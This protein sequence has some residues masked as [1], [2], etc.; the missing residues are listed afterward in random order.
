MSLMHDWGQPRFAALQDATLGELSLE[1]EEALDYLDRLPQLGVRTV[2]LP[3]EPAL[4][5]SALELGLRVLCPAERL[6][7]LEM[8]SRMG[9]GVRVEPE[10]VPAACERDLD[11]QVKL[12]SVGQAPPHRLAIWLEAWKSFDRL[13]LCLED[14]QGGLQPEGLLR[15]LGF[16]ERLQTQLGT[17][18]PLAWSQ[19]DREGMAIF[20]GLS[21][22]EAGVGGVRCAGLGA[23]GWIPLDGLLVN[24]SLEGRWDGPTEWL[25]VYCREL[26]EAAGLEPAANYP[27]AGRDAFRTATG[28]HAMAMWR[29]HQQGRQE[30]VD[31]IYSGVPAGRFG[32]EQTIEVGPMSGRSNVWWWLARNEMRH[33]EAAVDRVLQAAKQHF[34]SLTAEEI[35]HILEGSP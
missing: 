3:L 13:E 33:D 2:E 26:M 24:L 32:F 7:D 11:V 14:E 9:A 30:L 22:L 27:V 5:E 6:E 10:L 8:L 15:L 31:R 16:M 17:A 20:A 23:G 18:F 25:A 21:A 12:R 1:R 19:Q 34:R 28:V 29:A 35:R 4:I